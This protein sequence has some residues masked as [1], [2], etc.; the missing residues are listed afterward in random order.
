MVLARTAGAMALAAGL[1]KLVTSIEPALKA[2]AVA[3]LLK[4]V[5]ARPAQRLLRCS[6]DGV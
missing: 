4:W 3:P 5:L 1:V 6:W 2:N